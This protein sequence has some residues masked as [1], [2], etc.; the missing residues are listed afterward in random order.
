MRLRGERLT[1]SGYVRQPV[2]TGLDGTLTLR[3]ETLGLELRAAPGREMRF[4]DP[5]TGRDL[6]SHD[7][8]AEDRLAEAAARR[9]AETRATAAEARVAELETLLRQRSG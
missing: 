6:R 5:A 7:E 8:K 9:A 1:P 4:R 2:E 3:S